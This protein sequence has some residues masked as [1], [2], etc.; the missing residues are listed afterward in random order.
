MIE[1]LA[2]IIIVSAVIACLVIGNR[3]RVRMN[4][5]RKVR[6]YE[7]IRHDD[8]VK[9]VAAKAKL[10]VTKVKTFIVHDD[11]EVLHNYHPKRGGSNPHF[12]WISQKIYD[13]KRS[14]MESV[15]YFAS[16]LDYIIPKEIVI[17]IVPSS[18][19]G[20]G[21]KAT[22]GL[23]AKMLCNGRADG[24]R[25]LRRSKGLEKKLR[26]GGS[27]VHENSIEVSDSELIKGKVVWLLDDVVTTGN[28]MK[29]CAEKL[30]Y[31][32]KEVHCIAVGA[33]VYYKNEKG[34]RE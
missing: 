17:S 5:F 29:V 21:D 32:A 2:A 3:I 25:C 16:Q 10:D 8:A 9:Q 24:T 22:I 15:Q 14:S 31:H 20:F 23:V 28:S 7:I 1:V 19:A 13:L 18:E 34:D 33:T 30:R 6:D 26:Y 12:D 11:I 27:R 4:F